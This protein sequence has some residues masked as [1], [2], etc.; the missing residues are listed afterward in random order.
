MVLVEEIALAAA[1]AVAGTTASAAGGPEQLLTTAEAAQLARRS[2]ETIRAWA[3]SG[4]LTQV[5][6]G[7]SR[8]LYRRE[9]LQAA[10]RGPWSRRS[11]TADLPSTRA[12]EILRHLR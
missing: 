2:P 1:V 12:E 8:P 5:S 11:S 7:S 10:L 4:R 3:K 6:G 9:D